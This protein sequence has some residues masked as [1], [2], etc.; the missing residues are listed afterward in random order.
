MNHV[1]IPRLPSLDGTTNEPAA[2]EDRDT[3]PA[4]SMGVDL[5]GLSVRISGGL[6]R[7][8]ADMTNYRA[9]YHMVR[10]DRASDLNS[11]YDIVDMRRGMEAVMAYR[12]RYEPACLI[13][14]ALNALEQIT[15]KGV[16][17]HEEPVSRS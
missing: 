1:V 12:V 2:L 8:L 3:P 5:P 11:L 17:A 10:C 13:V 15:S 16:S 7:G 6:H 4:A 14:Q 9:R